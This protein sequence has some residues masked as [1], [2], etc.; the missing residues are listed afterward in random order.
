[1]WV[2]LKLA[3][4]PRIAPMRHRQDQLG[5]DG[6][7]E[8]RQLHEAHPGV[9]RG[10]DEDLQHHYNRLKAAERIEPKLAVKRPARPADKILLDALGTPED[11]RRYRTLARDFPEVELGPDQEIPDHYQRLQKAFESGEGAEEE[12]ARGHG[13]RGGL[14]VDQPRP[15]VRERAEPRKVTPP[16]R[17]ADEILADQTREQPPTDLHGMPRRI[18]GLNTGDS[19]AHSVP[20]EWIPRSLGLPQ[21]TPGT[22]YVD[23]AIQTARPQPRQQTHDEWA[24][25]LAEKG[26]YLN[27]DGSRMTP[28]Q[29]QLPLRYPGPNGPRV[30]QQFVERSPETPA[31]AGRHR[32]AM[33]AYVLEKL[34]EHEYEPDPKWMAESPAYAAWFNRHKLMKKDGWDFTESG[35]G[36]HY[37]KQIGDK[38]HFITWENGPGDQNGWTHY[39]SDSPY[40]YGGARAYGPYDEIEEAVLNS[41]IGPLGMMGR[42]RPREIEDST[43]QPDRMGFGASPTEPMV[44]K[45]EGPGLKGKFQTL[46]SVSFTWEEK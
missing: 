41:K 22:H 14:T 5:L 8:Y 40:S 34:A 7:I 1:M 29:M 31:Y 20:P 42:P 35:G 15:P 36:N 46:N 10:P 21:R 24:Q 30:W 16:V 19:W 27:P 9:E 6:A 26:I 18:P 23:P 43:Y 17:S 11:V 38:H 25:G 37:H 12:K 3:A 13:N 45:S 33:V 2:A 39:I 32:A 28:E 4:N 44:M